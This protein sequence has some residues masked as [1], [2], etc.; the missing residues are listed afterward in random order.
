MD[1]KKCDIVVGVWGECL[2]QGRAAIHVCLM[3]VMKLFTKPL[4]TLSPAFCSFYRTLQ[5]VFH[6]T[7]LHSI[8]VL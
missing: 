3:A 6:R 5:I 1:T 2:E 8:L 4:E 7:P